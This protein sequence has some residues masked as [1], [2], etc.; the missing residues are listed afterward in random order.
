MK[1][2]EELKAELT[3]ELLELKRL[4]GIW[5]V[6]LPWYVVDNSLSLRRRHVGLTFSSFDS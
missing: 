4:T 1:T 3:R 6:V 2:L 5:P